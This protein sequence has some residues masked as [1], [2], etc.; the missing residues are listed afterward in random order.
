MVVQRQTQPNLRSK[1][2]A[3][4]NFLSAKIVKGPGLA[5]QLT[6]QSWRDGAAIKYNKSLPGLATGQ[7]QMGDGSSPHSL[8][9]TGIGRLSRAAGFPTPFSTA[10][11]VCGLVAGPSNALRP[12]I[13]SEAFKL[14]W[15]DGCATGLRTRSRHACI[16]DRVLTTCPGSATAFDG[17][18]ARSHGSRLFTRKLPYFC[19]PAVSFLISPAPGSFSRG[20]PSHRELP[21]PR[22]PFVRLSTFLFLAG[23]TIYF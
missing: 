11:G 10:S 2:Q 18:F 1:I 9:R 7:G 4:K 5:R 21:D 14:A 3:G 15:A 8:S 20:L 17:A 16:S 6:G 12:W 22:V 13:L 23:S 19:S